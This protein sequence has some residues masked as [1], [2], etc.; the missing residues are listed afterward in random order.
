[1]RSTRPI[2]SPPGSP[3]RYSIEIL[4]NFRGGCRSISSSDIYSDQS[5]AVCTFRSNYFWWFDIIS[6]S[7]RISVVAAITGTHN[8]PHL[9][10]PRKN[11]KEAQEKRR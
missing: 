10:A 7:I 2:P 3:H 8:R 4:L 1:M 9:L 6:A 11:K 5:V